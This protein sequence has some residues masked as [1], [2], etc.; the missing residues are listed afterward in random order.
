[1]TKSVINSKMNNKKIILFL[2]AV[3][4]VFFTQA[5]ITGNYQIKGADTVK[6]F[7]VG[8]LTNPNATELQL[9]N[10]TDTVPGFLFNIG[11]GIT[12]FR[13]ALIK[14]NSTTYL[15]GKDTL[16]VGSGGSGGSTTPG[17]PTYAVQVNVNGSFRGYANLMYDTVKNT[18]TSG[19]INNA[20]NSNSI[21]GAAIGQLNTLNNQYGY[22]L[23]SG[24]T[25][26]QFSLAGGFGT[27]AGSYSIAFGNNVFNNTNYSSTF[28]NGLLNIYQNALVAGQFNDTTS[29]PGAA[30]VGDISTYPVFSIGDGTSNA[31]RKNAFT[32]LHNGAVILNL[33]NNVALD[34]VLIVDN[35]GF[36]QQKKLTSTGGSGIS[37]ISL[38]M[39]TG[40][41][42]S[43]ST[44]SASG[45]FTVT[46]PLSNGVTHIVGGAFTSSPVVNGDIT[47]IDWT[48][49]T[50][51]PTT[52][53]G[54]GITNA[55]RTDQTYV[56]PTWLTSLPWSKITTTPTS[57]A[58]YGIT[59]PIVLTSG[60]YANPSWITQLVWSKITSTPTTLA[61]YGIT[62]NIVLS[63]N[64]RTGVVISKNAD[65]LKNLPIDTTLNRNNYV[66]TFDSTNHKFFLS[67]AGTGGGA[68]NFSGLLD[69]VVS[70][71][72]NNQIPV[73]VTGTGKWTNTS[74]STS[75][76]SE[77]TNLYW[78]PA[79]FD[80][81]FATK[82]TDSLPEGTTNLYF[83]NARARSAVSA[84]TPLSYSSATG[85]FSIQPVSGS[86]NGYFTS[87]DWTTILGNKNK[88]LVFASSATTDGTQG[89]FRALTAADL[90]NLGSQNLY[91]PNGL[92]VVN[93]ST[94]N[95]GGG[96]IQTTSI[97][98]A[99]S[100]TFDSLTSLNL[101]HGTLASRV[102][103]ISTDSIVVRDV[104]GR[105]WVSP[106]SAGTGSS[107]TKDTSI[108]I[109]PSG[110][111]AT[112]SNSILINAGL[113]NLFI[114]GARISLQSVATTWASFDASTGT[115]TLTN[116]TF[117]NGDDVVVQ[118][119]KGG[120][121]AVV[122]GSLQDV[123]ITSPT[124][125]QV[126]TYNSASGKWINSAAGGSGITALTGDITASGSGSVAATLATVNSNT[127]A[128]G[129]ATHV[130][131]FTVNGK[132]LI[133]AASTISIQIAESQVTNL[134]TD[135][136]A[137]AP[138]ASP[139]F[140]GTPS[141]PTGTTAV[142]QSVSDNST[143]LSTTAYSDRAATNAQLLLFSAAKTANYTLVLGDAG[144]GIQMNVASANTV[145]I[146]PNSS[147]AFAIGT[148]I[149]IEQIGAGAST[150]T[151][152]AGVT[153]HGLNLV[154]GGQYG[155]ISIV[156][157]GTD[158]W[159]AL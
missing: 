138:L 56:N 20:L 88:N 5:Q 84:T 153:V 101:T 93:D 109:T 86:Q 4:C 39:P 102:T 82:K 80:T 53:T 133:T 9:E 57:L 114:N 33:K 119:N 74:V 23:G 66:L 25:T 103:N 59:D 13:R 71:P 29:W 131:S 157:K 148:T 15:I 156:K 140:T 45:T 111:S 136:A 123:N 49:I 147:V 100:L 22:A 122:L 42:V 81:R 3:F 145:T 91:T 52:V 85:V 8:G 129:D 120:S 32:I 112:Y 78:T 90:P 87:T 155:V 51:T 10:S 47:S 144:T 46:T 31:V 61:G 58:G 70:S 97:H 127:G 150:I 27:T 110:G 135:L 143:K 12:Q 17:G 108:N 116:G 124:N 94:I 115:I 95:W 48:K 98:G 14:I 96:L 118:Y 152:G 69:V 41:S 37:N 105:L 60:S 1:M 44:L 18:F 139:T 54:Y 151:P 134:T 68:T 26:N 79:R 55:V 43:P 104:A 99:Q 72:T 121:T 21:Y 38:V 125:G 89:T 149:V 92:T 75:I 158:D 24:N 30:S 130:G 77:G 106:L 11:N 16:F 28:G 2:I 128:W 7:K 107:G 132:G 34:S 83:T 40:F 137:K 6:I 76:I 50:N 142:T 117:H 65:S 141:L 159:L 154:T 126:L 35:N 36:I 67:P 63:V 19:G 64:G 62:D 146:P 73:Y 113:L